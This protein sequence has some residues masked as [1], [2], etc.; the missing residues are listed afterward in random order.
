M[1]QYQLVYLLFRM[2]KTIIEN[3]QFINIDE[4]SF[5]RS[6]YSTFS[7]IQKGTNAPILYNWSIWQ[8]NEIL[9]TFQAGHWFAFIKHGTVDSKILWVFLS[10]I[11]NISDWIERE[12]GRKAELL[13]ENAPTHKSSLTTEIIR[14]QRLQVTFLPAYS[15]EFAP[16]ELIFGCIQSKIKS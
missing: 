16:V 6:L 1:I 8:S 12:T 7:W 13:L 15:P 10:F 5:E 2:L 11:A 9:E 4:W 14:E 3:L